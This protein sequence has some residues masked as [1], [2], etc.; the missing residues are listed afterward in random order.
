LLADRRPVRSPLLRQL[1]DL[2]SLPRLSHD[3]LLR[4]R[5]GLPR[6]W[7]DRLL[8]RQ[9]GLPRLSRDRLLRRQRGLQPLSHDR[10][11]RHRRRAAPWTKKDINSFEEAAGEPFEIPTG[12]LA[13]PAS[14]EALGSG[15]LD[16]PVSICRP[17][18]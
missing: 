2:R 8:R 17:F 5:R 18:E 14:F 11:L 7:R 6:L 15:I 12:G 1:H 3:R 16:R 10:L 13:P 4:Q 9:R